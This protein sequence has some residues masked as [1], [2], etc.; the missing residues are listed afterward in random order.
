MRAY[1][2]IFDQCYATVMLMRAYWTIFDHCY[3]TTVVLTW[4][5][6]TI[7]DQCYATTA[8]PMRACLIHFDQCYATTVMLT[9]AYW[10]HFGG[11]WLILCRHP[12]VC[13]IQ[14]NYAHVCVYLHCAHATCLPS[15]CRGRLLHYVCVHP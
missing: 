12:C 4:A 9:W 14:R 10:T 6:L 3:A 11:N 1:L 8:T 5:C 7:F 15:Q 13:A 2:T